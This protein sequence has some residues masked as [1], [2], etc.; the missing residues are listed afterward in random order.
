[1]QAS[2][3]Q[4]QAKAADD[5]DRLVAQLMD[6]MHVVMRT[7]GGHGGFLQA[8]DE[9][10]LSLSQ[11]KALQLLGGLGSSEMSLK[12][13]GDSLGLSLPT[14][15][16]AVDGLVHRGL[17]TRTEDESDRRMKRVKVT[18]EAEE[19]MNHLFDV[20]FAELERV[21]D[22]LT[23]RERTKLAGALELVLQREE[24]AALLPQKETR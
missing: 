19:L 3:A 8:V 2:T 17:V 1:V 7:C 16:R 13:M 22:L 24:I 15:S 6:F 11:L 23:P 5:R 9:L 14:I 20:R 18:P 10:G 12:Q 21:F 4:K